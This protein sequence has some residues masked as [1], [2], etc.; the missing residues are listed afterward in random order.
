MRSGKSVRSYRGVRSDR[1]MR[2]RR[3]RKKEELIMPT[4]TAVCQEAIDKP[5]VGA[6]NVRWRFIISAP[7]SSTNEPRSTVFLVLRIRI[8][9][10]LVGTLNALLWRKRGGKWT[11]G[12]HFRLP[13]LMTSAYRKRQARGNP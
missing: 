2:R 5:Q 13:R 8:S 9:P 7:R 1:R 10:P 11:Q 6:G 12:D 3:S 4:W